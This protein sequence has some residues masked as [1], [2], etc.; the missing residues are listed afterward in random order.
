MRTGMARTMAGRILGVAATLVLAAALGGCSSVSKKDHELVMQEN[1][2][3]RD[4]MAALETESRSKDSKIAEL[5]AAKAQAAQPPAVDDFGTSPGGRQ[6]SPGT[7]VREFDVV[8]DV[9]FDSG[10]ATV[11]AGAKPQL[12][13]IAS[14]IKSRYSGYQVRVEGHTDSDPIRK[15]KWKTNDAL[16]EARAEAVKKYLASKGISSSKIEAVGMGSSEPKGSKKESRRVE[17]K[18][19]N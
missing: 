16:S 2:E 14:T 13:R 4:R 17:I 9:L 15:S 5:E 19:L 7:V 6:G 10:Q 8:G 3:L 12:D 1:Q 18:V 11:K